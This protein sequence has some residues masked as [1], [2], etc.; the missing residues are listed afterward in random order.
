M[1]VSINCWYYLNLWIGF[2]KTGYIEIKQYVEF[3]RIDEKPI[4]S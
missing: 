2:N 4:I 1:N 3:K